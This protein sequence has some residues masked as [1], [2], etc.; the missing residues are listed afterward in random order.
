V[1]CSNASAR[2]A[3][4][5]LPDAMIVFRAGS[6]EHPK[7]QVLYCSI[8]RHSRLQPKGEISNPY[9]AASIEIKAE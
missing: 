1:Y 3:F 8:A 9:L 6:D 7:P 2:Q 5:A 4:A